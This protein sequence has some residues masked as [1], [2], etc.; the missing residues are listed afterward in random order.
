MKITI[1]KDFVFD[2]AKERSRLKKCFKGQQLARQNAIVDAFEARDFQ[3]C[4]DLY[5]KLPYDTKHE[6]DEQEYVGEYFQFLVDC[7]TRGYAIQPEQ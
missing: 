7:V 5:S 2:L 6:C 1:K 4:G 3:K